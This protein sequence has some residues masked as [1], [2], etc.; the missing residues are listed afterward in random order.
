MLPR[1]FGEPTIGRCPH[2]GLTVR[3]PDEGVCPSCGVHHNAPVTQQD[4]DR[5]ER[6]RERPEGNPH[7]DAQQVGGGASSGR[8]PW[9]AFRLG[10]A[11]IAAT[12]LLAKACA[13]ADSQVGGKDPTSATDA[14]K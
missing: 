11:L 14:T 13:G 1:T 6:V 10:L 9:L 12:P 7:K 3:F 2:C 5:I 4:L 8:L